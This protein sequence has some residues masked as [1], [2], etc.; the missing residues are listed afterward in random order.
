VQ[1]VSRKSG[2]Q[3]PKRSPSDRELAIVKAVTGGHSNRQIAEMLRISEGRVEA[4][5]QRIFALAGVYSR[6]QLVRFVMENIAH[7]WLCTE[8]SAVRR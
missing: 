1:A 8:K 3:P 5:L 6:S 4:V 7:D 2:P